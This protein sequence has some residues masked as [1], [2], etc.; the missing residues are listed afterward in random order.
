MESLAPVRQWQAIKPPPSFTTPGGRAFT[1]GRV[2]HSRERPPRDAHWSDTWPIFYEGKPAGSLWRSLNY[3]TTADGKPR[4]QG[5]L[6]E[7]VWSGGAGGLPPTGIGFDVAAF[8]TPTEALAAW[9]RNAD[10][11]LD[12]RAGKSV[13]N[14]M[15]GVSKRGLTSLCSTGCGRQSVRSLGTGDSDLCGLC[16]TVANRP[17][18]PSVGFLYGVPTTRPISNRLK[19]RHFSTIDNKRGETQYY[20]TY[21]NRSGHS[22]TKA[23]F[24]KYQ[25][26]Y[27]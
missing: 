9:G 22:I 1:L 19:V 20:V 23:E 15:G 17:R 2:E 3:G 8:D 26:R 10:G 14:Q 4:W 13:R 6:R 12:W 18:N 11:V 16:R 27:K 21:E 7:L 5:S 25:A 24:D